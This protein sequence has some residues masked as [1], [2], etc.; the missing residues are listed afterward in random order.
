MDF[1]LS[2]LLALP[3]DRRAE[4]ERELVPF[5]RTAALGELAPGVAHDVANPL[6]GAIGLVD[7][8][9]GD[10]PAGSDEAERVLMLQRTIG[11]IKR[12][13]QDLLD[14]ARL[15]D[16]GRRE[17]DLQRAARDA[18]RL[19]RHGTR[20]ALAVE[21]RY[22]GDA[23]VV[24]CPQSLLVQAIL[25]LLLAVP[26]GHVVVE[27]D[28]PALRVSP[29]PESTVGSLVAARIAADHDATLEHADGSLALRWSG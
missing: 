10:L 6:F 7:L 24:P 18:L 8:L 28:G 29:E 16:N 5:A 13:L 11:E 17:G 15:T 22:R 4:V 25:Q 9:L 20:R 26:D 3:D 1:L 12:T 2:T 19:L 27:V 23:A 21:E 14:L